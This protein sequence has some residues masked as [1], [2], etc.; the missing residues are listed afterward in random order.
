MKSMILLALALLA[1]C[2]T[3]Y[4]HR[5]MPNFFP[6]HVEVHQVDDPGARCGNPAA[7]WGCASRLRQGIRGPTVLV[8]IRRDLPLDVKECVLL[9]EMKHGLGY[10]HRGEWTGDCGNGSRR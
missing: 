8:Y 2:A 7:K 1:G 3:E 5:D 4:W 6:A 10:G 9:H